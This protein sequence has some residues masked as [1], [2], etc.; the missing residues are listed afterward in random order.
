MINTYCLTKILVHCGLARVTDT[1]ICE[2]LPGKSVAMT[3]SPLNLT[4]LRLC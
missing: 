1:L 2:L 4:E 3:H